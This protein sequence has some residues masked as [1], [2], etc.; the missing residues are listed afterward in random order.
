VVFVGIAMSVTAF[1]VLA[2]ILAATGQN[3]TR[4]GGVA[5]GVA[6]VCDLVAWFGMA[7]VTAV[8]AHGGSPCC[9]STWPSWWRWSGSW[10]GAS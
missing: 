4:L 10:W 3:R 2:R 6:A 9:R 7:M 1:P 8:P 5:L